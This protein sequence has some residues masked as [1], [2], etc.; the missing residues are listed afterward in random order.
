MAWM[1][2]LIN[3]IVDISFVDGPG[4][5]T[6]VFFQGCN[7]HCAYCHNPET[8]ALCSSCGQCVNQCPASALAMKDGR[9][10]W[11]SSKCVGCDACIRACPIS[12]S[13]K[14]V[15]MSVEEVLSR[16]QQN[17]PFISGLTVSGG[18]CTLWESFLIPLFRG[19]HELGLNCLIDS[20]GSFDFQAHPELLACAD[21]VMLDIKSTFPDEY[22]HITGT[23]GSGVLERAVFLAKA[24][25][26]TE[27]RTVCCKELRSQDVVRKTAQALAPYLPAGDIVYRIIPYRPYGVRASE[28]SRFHAPDA[29]ALEDLRRTA[30]QC[31]MKTVHIT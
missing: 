13:P 21:G 6:A 28:R 15:L 20:N 18:E 11:D 7:Y 31:G 24:G 30:L 9:V 5:R 27:V 26:L 16:L 17:C 10:V 12:S 4:N 23:N 1:N 19:A 25:K 2:A 8:M 22:L 14:A 3:Q 29:P